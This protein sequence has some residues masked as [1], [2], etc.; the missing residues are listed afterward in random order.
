MDTKSFLLTLILIHGLLLPLT[1]AVS[2][3]SFNL[4]SP[5]RDHRQKFVVLS[6]RAVQLSGPP[7]PF[8]DVE[9]YQ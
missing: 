2:R 9:P 4:V 7:A 3:S 1:E 5:G 6:K 8:R